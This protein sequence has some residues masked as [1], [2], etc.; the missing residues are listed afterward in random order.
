M[1]RI[2]HGNFT[3]RKKR[4]EEKNSSTDMFRGWSGSQASPD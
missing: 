1:R 3:T 4:E 2:Q